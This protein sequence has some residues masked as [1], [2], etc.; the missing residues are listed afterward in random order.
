MR[1]EYEFVTGEKICVD[2]DGKFENIMHE[3]D[4]DLKNNDLNETEKHESL[5]LFYKSAG[6]GDMTSDV[7]DEVLENFYKENIYQVIS[8]L[9][10]D[11]KELIHKL[12][13]DS[14]PLTQEQCAN[15]LGVKIEEIEKRLSLI[16]EKLRA[17]MEEK[18][19]EK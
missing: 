7:L 12:Y 17:L 16:L 6:M 14:K 1:I 18:W 4:N 15:Y 2:V 13:L 10:P 3:L 8:Q 9:N 5:S 11:E 19:S